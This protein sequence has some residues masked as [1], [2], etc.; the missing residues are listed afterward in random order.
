MEVSVDIDY[1][2]LP[3]SVVKLAKKTKFLIK[4]L[5]YVTD[6]VKVDSEDARNPP[7][8]VKVIAAL[9]TNQSEVSY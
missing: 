5:P 6:S 8:K 9:L 7:N 4:A 1:E 2:R 3:R